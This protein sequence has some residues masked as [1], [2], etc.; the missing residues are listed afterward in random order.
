[1]NGKCGELAHDARRAFHNETISIGM[2]F[3]ALQMLHGG[4]KEASELPACYS[5]THRFV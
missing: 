4:S 3:G 2:D 5:Q 1:M